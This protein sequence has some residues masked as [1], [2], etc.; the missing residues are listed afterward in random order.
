MI[1]SIIQGLLIGFTLIVAI[2]AQNAFVLR[3]GL[4][5][6]HGWLVAGICACCDLALVA[7]GVA[8]LAPLITS[9][10][11]ALQLARWGGVGWLVW[12]ASIACRRAM[13]PRHL[14]VAATANGLPAMAARPVI[15]ATLA[16]TLLN[17]HV[18]LDTVVMLGIIG[19]QQPSP[20]G[21]V[22]GASLASLVWFFG[23]VGMAH[24]LSPRL[25]DPR[26][27]QGIDIA[28]GA[29]MLLVAWQLATRTL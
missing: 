18:Y 24:W 11:T 12:Q 25:Q 6:E 14:E 4:R 7:A 5:R 13:R 17:P 23:L 2:G 29:I 26:W 22:A 27:W 16:V 3:Q 9:S 20:A 1:T 21:F 8:G 10:A 19:G 15:L 28:V